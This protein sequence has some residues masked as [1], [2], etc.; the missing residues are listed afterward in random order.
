LGQLLGR[1]RRI[2]EYDT[3]SVDFR[4]VTNTHRNPCLEKIRVNG[5]HNNLRGVFYKNRPNP[6]GGIECAVP[7][8]LIRKILYRFLSPTPRRLP[9]TR[10]DRLMYL[11]L[12]EA[13]PHHIP[14]GV[15]GK[16][17]GF[18]SPCIHSA[19]AVCAGFPQ[20]AQ[21]RSYSTLPSRSAGR[22]TVPTRSP[23]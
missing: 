22:N 16:A 17:N 8:C 1:D 19:C 2:A 18:A 3:Q 15:I 21:P 23:R 20:G 13:A 7:E 4:V 9:E 11:D 12:G 6:F 14:P 10:A 5:Y